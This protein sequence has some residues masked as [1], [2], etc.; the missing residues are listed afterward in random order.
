MAVER[1]IPSTEPKARK[2]KKSNAK[3]KT[4]EAELRKGLEQRK[5]SWTARF[6]DKMTVGPDGRMIRAKGTESPPD[7]IHCSP[8]MNALIECKLVTVPTGKEHLASIAFNRLQE[9]Q[10]IDLRRFAK[11]GD[12]HHAFI[13]VAFYNG[14]LGG[15][16]LYRAWVVPYEIWVHLRNTVGRKS[17]QMSELEKFPAL[18][19]R[20]VSGK[21][22]HWAVDHVLEDLTC[23]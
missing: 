14:E 10:E 5:R 11:I 20:W 6:T 18:E 12:H 22:A 19:L 13:G 9:H 7:L 15:K 4:F 8:R 23:L 3:A 17:L 16:R 1:A 2:R 21:E